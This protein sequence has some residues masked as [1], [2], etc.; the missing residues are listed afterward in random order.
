MDSPPP[1]HKIELLIIQPTPFCNIDCDYCYLPGRTDRRRMQP[2]VLDAVFRSVLTSNYVGRQMTVVWHAGEP[3]TLPPAWYS[4]AFALAEKHR[5]E[6]LRL[7]HHFQSNGTLLDDTWIPLLQQPCVHI[8][9][10]I[11]GPAWLHDVRRRTRGGGGTHARSMRGLALLRSMD[12]PFHVITVLTNRTLD[13]ADEL[14]DFYSENEI[15]M[16]AFNIEEMDGINRTSTLRGPEAEVRFR[17]FLRRF[18]ERMR[19]DPERLNLREMQDML[20]VIREKGLH[21]R[22]AQDADPMRILSVD[23]AGNVASFSPELLGTTNP[24]YGNFCF[25]NVLVDDLGTIAARI[26]GSRL[27]AD[28]QAGI[29]A[30]AQNCAWFTWCGGGSPCNKLAETGSLLSTET[31]YCRLTRQALL[32][33]VLGLIEDTMAD[34]VSASE[35]SA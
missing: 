31:M 27:H 15:R 14:F 6:S 8:G 24:I 33:V 2:D 34:G 11:D 19:G 12:I 13:Y 21:G 23:V 22:H 18:L 10:S 17:R 3:L 4:S 16:V 7:D 32:D 5:P 1:T 29:A 9:L 30:C 35:V 26:H 25:G 20:S 28:I